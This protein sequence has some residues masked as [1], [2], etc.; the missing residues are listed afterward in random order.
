MSNEITPTITTNDTENSDVTKLSRTLDDVKA[1]ARELQI[2][3]KENISI[4]KLLEKIEAKYK[5]NEKE[6]DVTIS[7]AEDTSTDTDEAKEAAL[8]TLT[9]NEFIHKQKREAEK[10]RI[11]TIID[12]DSRINNQTTTC[13]V[14]ASNEFFDLGT[15]ILLLNERVEVRQ[16]HL[17]VLSEL[18]IPQHIKN[19]KDPSISVMVMR[20]RYTIQYEQDE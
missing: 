7:D 13:T 20:P 9:L 12:N 11:V 3:F 8:N 10:T 14:S 15:V 5:V 4:E 16:G 2:S 18:R 1:E 6:S 17:N 19:P